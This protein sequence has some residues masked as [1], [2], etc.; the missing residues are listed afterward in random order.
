MKI[1]V[2]GAAGFIASHVSKAFLNQGHEVFAIDDLSSGNEAFIDKRVGFYRINICDPNI[3]RLFQVQRFDVLCHHAAQIDVRA[4]VNNPADDIDV[5]IQ[6]LVNLMEAGRRNGLQKV[7]LA[8]T[9]GAIYGEPLHV[10]Q[11][12]SHPERPLS[13]YGI[14][15]LASELYLNYYLKTYGIP[16]VALRYANVF[17]PRQNPHGEAGVIA[18][19]IEH[20]LANRQ[21]QIF[22]DGEQTRDFVYVGDVVQANLKA[23]AYRESGCFN[24]GT[25]KETSINTVFDTLADLTNF[26]K[27]AIRAPGKPG[28]QRRSVLDNQFAYKQMGWSPQKSLQAGL[29]E[30]VVWFKK[31]R[32]TQ[33]Q[34]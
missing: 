25:G 19:F 21:P 4:S 12:E 27:P 9:G 11:T 7:I 24:I 8:S 15:K 22:G 23:L 18:I 28:E 14:N 1:L 31:Q 34:Y 32:T 16:Y 20:L 29:A 5:N 10:P 17:G 30:T 33:V 13:P 3:S 26:S 6:G 2:T